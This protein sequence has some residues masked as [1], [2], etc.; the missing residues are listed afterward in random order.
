MEVVLE[1]LD[2]HD[3][4]PSAEAEPATTADTADAAPPAAGPPPAAPEVLA[5]RPRGRPKGSTNKP[6][7]P[8]KEPEVQR[9]RKRP[10]SS[11]SDSSSDEPQPRLSKRSVVKHLMEDDMETQVL[12]FLTARKQN[13][14]QQRR[15]LWQNLAASGLRY[16]TMSHHVIVWPFYACIDHNRSF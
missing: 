14:E 2:G 1:P 12:R 13:Q 6:K 5:K 8:A 9:K 4:A 16:I 3:V 10:P 7:P 15:T 11:S